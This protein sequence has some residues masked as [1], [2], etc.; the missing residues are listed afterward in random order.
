MV[1]RW[2]V[3]LIYL[4][5]AVIFYSFY[6]GYLSYF[7]LL[8][9]ALF[10]ILSLLL[11]IPSFFGIQLELTNLP[12]EIFIGQGMD[13]SLNVNRKHSSTSFLPIPRLELKYH[14]FNITFSK[15]Y[16]YQGF[17]HLTLFGC[18]GDSVPIDI[19]DNH[20]GCVGIAFLSV[21][22]YDYLGLFSASL[23]PPE[24]RSVLIYPHAIA[25]VPF[26]HFPFDRTITKGLRPLIGGG[27]SEDHDL[28]N[29]RIGDP[30]NTIHWK[31]SSKLDEL[32][33]REPL[34]SEKGK[35]LVCFNLFGTAD[36][37]DSVFGQIAYIA[38]VLVSRMAEFSL[39][40]YNADEE[41]CFDDIVTY[42]DY[43]KAIADIF[44]QP[45]PVSGKSID[46]HAIKNADWYCI[47]R[48]TDESR[49][50]DDAFAEQ[51]EDSL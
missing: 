44:R 37:M 38:K 35:L 26:P 25:P 2:L 3:Y 33:V 1:K 15:T 42:D 8:A 17:T 36:E 41:L 50:T 45:L 27:F 10:P 40:Y 29:Y 9:V 4:I 48:P 5:A 7:V 46:T 6:D 24:R 19:D 51:E 30:L 20:I 11:A 49:D 31:L 14:S 13:V 28:R 16:D 47:V 43:K 39:C 21:K 22:I 12:A 23:K 32:I 18:N 34:F